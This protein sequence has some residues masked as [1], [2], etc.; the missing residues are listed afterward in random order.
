MNLSSFLGVMV[1]LTCYN[2][3]LRSEYNSQDG[4]KIADKANAV[5][6]VSD[7]LTE[8]NLGR[9][10]KACKNVLLNSVSLNEIV[11]K[12]FVAKQSVQDL[13]GARLISTS[14]QHDTLKAVSRQE[15]VEEKQMELV[16]LA[17]LKGLHDDKVFEKQIMLVR[18]RLFREYAV[19]LISRKPGS[20][21]PGVD[22]EFYDKEKENMFEELVNYLRQEI[23]HPNK[24]R[25][26]A[27]KRV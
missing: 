1:S 23:Y 13:L 10:K 17:K 14:N 27:V 8:I 22:K 21:T 5:S 15:Q 20:Q 25:A 7:I 19:E 9:R 12:P 16:Q 18:S 2:S 11:R 4:G 6:N 24:Y 26:S 3:K